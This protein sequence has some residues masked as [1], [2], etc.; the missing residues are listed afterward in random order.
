MFRYEMFDFLRYFVL[1]ME[2]QQTI[3]I[4][5]YHNSYKQQWDAFVNGAKN[6]TFLF[7]RDFM[8]YHKDRFDDFSLMIFVKDELKAIL[9]ACKVNNE[10]M[11]HKWLTYGGL[12]VDEKCK[13][14]LFQE[15]FKEVL[16]YLKKQNIARLTIKSIPSIY[17][18]TANDE[19]LFLHQLYGSEMTMNLGSVVYN[20][21]EIPVS[22]SIVRNAKN[23][24]KKGIEIRKTDDF[25][26]FWNELLLPRLEERF[27]TKPVHTLSEIKYLKSLFPEEIE[28]RAAFLNNEMIAGTV[29]FHNKKFVKSQYIASKSSYNK[30]GGLD[31]LHYELIKNLKTAY[32][33]FGTS[34][35]NEV[36]NESLLAW[37][38]QFGARTLV[39]PTFSFNINK[40]QI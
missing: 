2:K 15:L 16:L 9:P 37:K 12:L 20:A 6:S 38:E 1:A 31:L 24:L 7:R 22:K 25:D 27:Q 13:F 17:G 32:F 40:K 35:G 34:S 21:A 5:R 23:A 4:I 14:G 29:L 39:F 26:T 36:V 33:D 3:E 18:E 19:L 10:V 30:L 28:L 11:S 8:E